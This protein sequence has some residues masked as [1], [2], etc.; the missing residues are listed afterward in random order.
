M[1]ILMIYSVTVLEAGP[2][3]LLTLKVLR[4]TSVEAH[5]MDTVEERGMNM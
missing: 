3:A 2:Q 1:V 5:D 4:Y